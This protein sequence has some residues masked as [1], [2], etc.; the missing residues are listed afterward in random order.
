MIFFFSTIKQ[1]KSNGYN[2]YTLLQLKAKAQN[3]C[4]C[5]EGLCTHFE[6]AMEDV[7]GSLV[8]LFIFENDFDLYNVQY[9]VFF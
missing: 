3:G 9:L 4:Q 2:L 7:P 8:L 5:I 6:L 1:L